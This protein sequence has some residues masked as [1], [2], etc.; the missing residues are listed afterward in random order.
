[1]PLFDVHHQERAQRILLRAMAGGRVPHAYIFHGPAGIGKR[2]LADRLAALLLCA[3]QKKIPPPVWAEGAFDNIECVDA[4]G[5]CD[6]CHTV[7]SGNHP[8]LHPIYR[9]LRL[10]HPDPEVRRR[11]G[12]DLGID[13]IRE[14]VIN[15]AGRSPMRGRAKVFIIEEAERM[16]AAA[17]NAL[18]KT[19]EEPPPPTFLILLAKSIEQ[20]LPTTRSRCQH[21]PFRTL[22]VEFIEKKLADLRPELSATDATYLARACDG[23]LGM[24]LQYA[25]D[26]IP[27]IKR[28][29]GQELGELNPNG[30]IVFAKN[31]A[32]RAGEYAKR[33]GER[34]D[35]DTGATEATRVGL[36]AMLAVTATFYTDAMRFLCGAGLNLINT[37]QKSVIESIAARHSQR[38][39]TRAIREIAVAESN[40]DRNAAP[41][42]VLE[43]MAIRLTQCL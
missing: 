38:G 28:A 29:I 26:G 27:E 42:L 33:L 25:C 9:D 18:L 3:K 10:H 30:V 7:A 41:P 24:A 5:Q 8:D 17:Q 15:A 31:L 36:R 35:A 23:R 34:D 2:M 6:D 12:I 11:K 1:V 40:I 37:D 22:P 13:I 21:V 39:L 32:E 14:F 19:L 43:A 16:S 20:L 4:C